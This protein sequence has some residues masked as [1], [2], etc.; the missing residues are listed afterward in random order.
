M[1][2]S[3]FRVSIHSDNAYPLQRKYYI[4]HFVDIN[5]SAGLHLLTHFYQC[6]CW[7]GLGLGLDSAISNVPAG[8]DLDLRKLSFGLT[9]FFQCF[10]WAGLGL[11][12]G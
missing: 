10:C 7:T 4:L 8:L 11:G 1:E 6:F 12:L 2:S 9:H 3:P 5:V